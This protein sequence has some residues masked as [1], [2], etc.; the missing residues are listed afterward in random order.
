M[1]VEKTK[2]YNCGVSGCGDGKCIHTLLPDELC[3][4]CDSPMVAVP[5]GH[6]FCSADDVACDYEEI[7][8]DTRLFFVFAAK[9][10]NNEK[11]I[12]YASEPMPL[13][14]AIE[15]RKEYSGYP[16]AWIEQCKDTQRPAINGDVT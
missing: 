2:S 11:N 9:Y 10:E 7:K 3:P 8:N 14:A 4:C 5:S 6:K 15:K 16:F 12:K 13:K 1:A